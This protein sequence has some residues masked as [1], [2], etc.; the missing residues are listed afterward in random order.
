MIFIKKI[1]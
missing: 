1:F